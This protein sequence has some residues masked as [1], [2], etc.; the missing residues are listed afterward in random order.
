MLYFFL[1]SSSISSVHSSRVL[2]SVPALSFVVYL[3]SIPGTWYD[4]T[5]VFRYCCPWYV[6]FFSC[7]SSV[8]GVSRLNISTHQLPVEL[9]GWAQSGVD[10]RRVIISYIHIDRYED[11][12][13]LRS[14]SLRLANMN[15]MYY[16]MF[17]FIRSITKSR[18]D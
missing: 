6:I 7:D 10:I 8:R 9:L 4:N 12:W 5:S 13:V 14:Q 16:H 18:V 15:H 17:K 11:W 3:L 2:M 1:Y